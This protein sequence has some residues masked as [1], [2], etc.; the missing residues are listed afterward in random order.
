MAVGLLSLS[1][2]VGMVARPRPSGGGGFGAPK[3]SKA[4]AKVKPLAEVVASFATRLPSDPAATPCACGLG[5]SYAECC[6]PYHAEGRTVE[7]PERCL[8]SRFSAFA[9]RL[10]L[11]IITTTS[12]ENRDYR[13]DKVAWARTLDREGMF[14]SFDFVRLAVGEAEAGASEGESYLSFTATLRPRE[15]AAGEAAEEM[16]FSERSRFVRSKGGGWLYASGEVRTD[17]PGLA[18]RVLN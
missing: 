1:L 3:P 7:S 14:D 13:S 11:H 10:P 16:S 2:C 6:Q 15:A 12:R 4:K 18:G 17:A 5:S 8:R 9:Y